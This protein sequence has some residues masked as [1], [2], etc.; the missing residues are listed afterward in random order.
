MC[1]DERHE[2]NNNPRP[3]ASAPFLKGGTQ[4]RASDA[5]L[6]WEVFPTPMAGFPVQLPG[7]DPR[8]LV[9]FVSVG[10]VLSGQSLPPEQSPP[11]LDEVQPRRP[12]RDERVLYPRVPFEPLS[13]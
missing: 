2:P 1:L 11:S 5:A 9:D 7:G 13:H 12:L 6:V 10:E 4:K 8:C 3:Q